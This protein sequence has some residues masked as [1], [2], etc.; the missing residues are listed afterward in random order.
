[1]MITLI[2]IYKLTSHFLNSSACVYIVKL[3][4]KIGEKNNDRPLFPMT[5]IGI[6]M[7]KCIPNLLFEMIFEQI[8][9]DI[10][11]YFFFKG[12]AV[13]MCLLFFFQVKC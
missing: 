13:M 3:N 5:N 2:Y 9:S 12:R 11:D 1:M 4:L 7:T 10:H 8:F 6:I